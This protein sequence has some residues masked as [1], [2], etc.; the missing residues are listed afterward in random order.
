VSFLAVNPRF[1]LA[2]DFEST[3]SSPPHSALSPPPPPRRKKKKAILETSKFALTPPPF[4]KFAGEKGGRESST[5]RRSSFRERGGRREFEGGPLSSPSVFLVVSLDE[6]GST[7][8]YFPGSVS[9]RPFW[10]LF[11]VFSFLVM[12]DHSGQGLCR[13]GVRLGNNSTVQ[14]SN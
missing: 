2:R 13:T 4:P 8:R 1:S 12:T 14:Y 7:T 10:V 3:D 6:P 5:H 9:K 11:W